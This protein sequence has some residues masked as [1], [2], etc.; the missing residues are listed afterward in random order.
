MNV[1]DAIGKSGDE[2]RR[3]EAHVAGQA[4]QVDVVVAQASQ[5]IGIVVGPRPA[6]GDKHRVRQTQFPGGTNSRSL[7][8]IGDHHADFDARQPAFADGS[9]N[10]Q[11]V[12]T[13]A[14]QKDAELD[15]PIIRG[16]F[17]DFPQGQ[18]PA[19]CF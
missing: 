3:Q 12:R 14:G 5:H 16:S 10:G 6:F 9:R 18:S 2:F 1:E 13:A 8:H 11:E 4:D 17:Q 15:S 19:L 7:G